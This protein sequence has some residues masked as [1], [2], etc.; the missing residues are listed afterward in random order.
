MASR[1]LREE[2]EGRTTQNHAIA[3]SFY[4]SR[5]A[6]KLQAFRHWQAKSPPVL[7]FSGPDYPRLSL[8]PATTPNTTAAPDCLFRSRPVPIGSSRTQH[9]RW[10]A[11]R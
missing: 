4:I 5:N 3:I 6:G 2:R 9:L 7:C 8:P 10:T 11:F 1:L